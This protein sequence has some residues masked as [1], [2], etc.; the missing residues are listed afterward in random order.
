MLDVAIKSFLGVLALFLLGF[1][2]L[3]SCDAD[4]GK[5]RLLKVSTR[6]E[7][8]SALMVAEG[9]EKIL[10][11]EGSY[12]PLEILDAKFT[13]PVTITPVIPLGANFEYVFISGS[14]G[15]RLQSLSVHTP[16]NGGPSTSV[17]SIVG[18]S[19]DVVFERS[20]VFGAIDSD[21]TG[22]NGLHCENVKDVTFSENQIHD[23]RNGGV[24]LDSNEL[25]V[26]GN[27]IENIGNDGFKFISVENTLVEGNIGPR[28]VAPSDGAHLD[29][30]QFQGGDSRN[31]VIRGNASVPGVGAPSWQ[32]IFMD[33]ASYSN[34]LIERNTLVIASLR[35]ISISG[36][37]NI[38]IRYNTILDVARGGRK[39]TRIF[40]DGKVYGNI[41]GTYPED[42]RLGEYDGNLYIQNIDDSMPFSY[43]EFFLDW[44]PHGEIELKSFTPIPGSLAYKYGAEALDPMSAE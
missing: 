14:R 43:R 25:R 9:G 18:G 11:A 40:S 17:V 36:G 3:T 29:F 22:P 15:L 26:L 8:E 21:F 37:Q 35:G 23:V 30:I 24:F 28:Q 33:D 39:A 19:Q 5:S 2:A 1:A 34:V 6:E 27:V 31:I 10:L 7:L 12:G 42:K 16:T 38:V 41:L 20:E 4:V 13:D 44:E 32:G